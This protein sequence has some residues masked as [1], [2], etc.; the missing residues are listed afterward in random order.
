MKTKNHQDVQNKITNYT[1]LNNYAGKAS[2]YSNFWKNY[3]NERYNI[4]NKKLTCYV[5]LKPSDY[6][7]FEWNK[8]VK[9]DGQLCIV[10]KIYDYD[11][12]SNTT[13]KVDLITIQDIN[14]YTTNNYN[15]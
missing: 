3:I 2:I 15:A 6:N 5:D 12:N 11:V 4:Q 10:N 1:Y 9:I 13:T 7:Q 8:L 14:G